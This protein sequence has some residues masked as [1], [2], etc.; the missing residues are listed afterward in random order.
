MAHVLV[1][2]GGFGGMVAAERLAKRLAPEHRVTLVSRGERFLE[3]S[4]DA[5]AKYYS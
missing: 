5:R 2:G 1:L 3:G 4:S